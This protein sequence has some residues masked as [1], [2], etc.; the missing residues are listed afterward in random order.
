VAALPP[1]HH[2]YELH[3][4]PVLF[5]FEPYAVQLDLMRA[6]LEALKEGKDACLESPTGSG[7]TMALLCSTLGF[8]R[9]IM[10]K[11]RKKVTVVYASRTHA[12]LEQVFKE[13]K[14]SAYSRSGM[15]AVVLASRETTCIEEDVRGR[16]GVDQIAACRSLVSNHKCAPKNNVMYHANKEPVSSM[17][18]DL[19]DLGEYAGLRKKRLCPY[20]LAR[21]KPI[22]Q[23]ADLVLLPY[24][25]VLDADFRRSVEI[26]WNNA[27]VRFIFA[28]WEKRLI[29]RCCCQRNN[30]SRLFLTRRTT[31]SLRVKTAAALS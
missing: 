9:H 19:E 21:S 6:A 8:A 16:K 1:S 10:Q 24:P 20:F 3:S 11:K 25:Y 12:Q 18:M 23:N 26:D 17:L 31:W 22:L 2:M 30:I 7:K 5:P 27:I 4:I 29:C 13:F 14:A 28:L 15:R